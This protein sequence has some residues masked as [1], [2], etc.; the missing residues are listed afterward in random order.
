MKPSPFAAQ[1]RKD[2]KRLA[3]P[4]ALWAAVFAFGLAL[5]IAAGAGSASASAKLQLFVYRAA[6]RAVFEVL[7]VIL[8]AWVILEDP[9]SGTTAFWLT[10]PLPRLQVL[11][12]KLVLLAAIAAGPILASLVH[13]LAAHRGA[14]LGLEDVG[15]WIASSLMMRVPEVL[16]VAAFAITAET[17][18]QFVIAVVLTLIG[19]GIV[20]GVT[21]STLRVVFHAGPMLSFSRLWA[22]EVIGAVLAGGIV[23]WRYLNRHARAANAVVAAVVLALMLIPAYWPWDFV[24]RLRPVPALPPA[25]AAFLRQGEPPRFTMSGA[26]LG[27]SEPVLAGRIDPLPGPDGTVILPAS[28]GRDA[29]IDWRDGETG[30]AG[31]IAGTALYDPEEA[32]A[33]LEAA[34]APAR[35]LG[36]L[37]RTARAS[38]LLTGVPSREWIRR[39][40][41]KFHAEVAAS[42]RRYRI[43]GEMPL[44]LGA[45]ADWGHHHWVVR[46]E[47]AGAGWLNLDLDDGFLPSEIAEALGWDGGD[48][49]PGVTIER[50]RGMTAVSGPDPGGVSPIPDAVFALVNRARG[51]A[52]LARRK[53]FVS[54]ATIMADYRVQRYRV[55]FDHPAIDDGWLAQA[56]LVRIRVVEIARLGGILDVDLPPR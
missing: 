40:P 43:S 14:G 15:A 55:E 12:A 32:P 20:A 25:V 39:E 36:P 5:D 18:G 29:R 56:V 31:A 42:L 8:V 6:A 16:I 54:P 48:Y 30:R 49:A 19:A 27:S 44:R 50:R 28:L 26:T 9:P 4:F 13:L 3:L 51:Q 41:A 52:I 33:A 37:G 10:R 21:A 23:A 46:G 53:L 11:G 17:F 2:G 34:L 1:L 47:D 45:S 24:G 38:I 22:D 7:T 35:I